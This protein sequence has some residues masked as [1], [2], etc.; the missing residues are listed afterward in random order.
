MEL[1]RRYNSVFL[2]GNELCGILLIDNEGK[3]KRM[4]NDTSIYCMEHVDMFLK[5]EHFNDYNAKDFKIKL[6]FKITRGT[7]NHILDD[8]TG[9]K[10]PQKPIVMKT[11]SLPWDVKEQFFKHTY[12]FQTEY[13]LIM[14]CY[15]RE[16]GKFHW[17]TDK[18]YDRFYHFDATEFGF[19][20]QR[21]SSS[22]SDSQVKTQIV[23]TIAKNI[24]AFD[25]TAYQHA[26]LVV[27]IYDNLESEFEAKLRTEKLKDHFGTVRN[28]V[29]LYLRGE[30][31]ETIN[32][33]KKEEADKLVEKLNRLKR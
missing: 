18:E 31:F 16:K 33:D 27:D 6:D 8:C 21:T 2:D 13:V 14:N 12:N 30:K 1:E 28:Y 5:D 22:Q 11:T 9:V 7:K 25:K 4:V 20:F 17:Y 26:K 15:E 32:I 19:G 3:F 29:D 23:D 24:K 10:D